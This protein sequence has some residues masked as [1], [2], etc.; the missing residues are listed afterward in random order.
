MEMRRASP[1]LV[2]ALAALLL[3]QEAW[4]QATEKTITEQAQLWLGLMTQTRV[5]KPISL[6]N[7]VHFVPQG[8]FLART[9]VTWHFTESM[10]GT[11]GYAFGLLPVGTPVALERVEHRPWLQLLYVATFAGSWSLSERIRYEARFR[12]NVSDGEL[13]DGFGFTSRVRFALNIRRNFE[14]LTFFRDLV[15]YATVGDEVLLQF[16]ES[17]VYNT[18]DQN[19]VIAGLGVTRDKTSFQL[20]YVNRLVQGATG[21]DYTMNHMLALWVMQTFDCSGE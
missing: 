5:S 18:L 19:R 4:G 21:S 12:E 20:S 11:G 10:S 16:G 15:P 2:L 8:F 9:G 14:E 1:S 3:P 7:D 13:A 17:V 6:W